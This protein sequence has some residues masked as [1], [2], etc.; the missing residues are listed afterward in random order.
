MYFERLIYLYIPKVSI[1]V[2]LMWVKGQDSEQHEQH[3]NIYANSQSY[4]ILVM[5]I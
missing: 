3:V 1:S 5:N 4:D 2:S